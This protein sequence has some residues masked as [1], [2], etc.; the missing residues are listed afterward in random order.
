MASDAVPYIVY[1]PVPPS[2]N[3]IW[4][5]RGGKTGRVGLT[6]RYKAWRDAAGWELKRQ[7]AGIPPILCRYDLE[8]VVPAG[9]YDTDNFCKP[10]GDLLQACG[11]VSNDRNLHDLCVRPRK[12]SDVACFLTLRP[13][14][15]G[16]KAAPKP[17]GIRKA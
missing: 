5:F 9:L 13:D 8:L 12:R 1:L 2:A 10:I 14:I 16:A 17:R 3:H 4:Q 15:P 7:I 6:P 11:M